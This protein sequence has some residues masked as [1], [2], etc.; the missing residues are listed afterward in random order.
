MGIFS[1]MAAGPQLATSLAHDA[2]TETDPMRI[3]RPFTSTDLMVRNLPDLPERTSLLDSWKHSDRRM[4]GHLSF[5]S[6]EQSGI[7]CPTDVW[8]YQ[9]LF[10]EQRRDAGNLMA[11]GVKSEV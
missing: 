2:A 7:S 11:G 3:A 4:K 9:R 8:S 6:Y 1:Q 10:I 5:K